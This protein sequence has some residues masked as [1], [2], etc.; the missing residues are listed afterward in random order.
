MHPM[1]YMNQA[2]DHEGRPYEGG[3]G[4]LNIGQSVPYKYRNLPLSFSPHK[5]GFFLSPFLGSFL[6]N[7][8]VVYIIKY[9]LFSNIT[10]LV[11]K[12]NLS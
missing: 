9:S 6:P 7:R 11:F 4:G 8:L 10:I 12:I 5:Y 2:G 1:M 3:S